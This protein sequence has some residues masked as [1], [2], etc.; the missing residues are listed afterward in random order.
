M[1]KKIK[2][3]VDP[4]GY[5]LPHFPIYPLTTMVWVL[6]EQNRDAG[7]PRY[8][9]KG[10]YVF[11]VPIDTAILIPS[12][13]GGVAVWGT[14]RAVIAIQTSNVKKALGF[15]EKPGKSKKLSNRNFD[16]LIKIIRQYQFL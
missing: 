16:L 3:R 10:M 12:A 14:K 15:L 5:R 11:A 13:I 9:I 7:K 1:K 4:Q 2:Y 8:F 6:D